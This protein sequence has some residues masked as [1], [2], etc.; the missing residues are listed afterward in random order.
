VLHRVEASWQF[1]WKWH[2]AT[3]NRPELSSNTCQWF[4]SCHPLHLQFARGLSPRSITSTT[5]SLMLMFHF[6]PMPTDFGNFP[7]VQ[8]G[9]WAHIVVGQ[10]NGHTT[11]R[12]HIYYYDDGP[13]FLFNTG[14]FF[15][16]IGSYKFRTVYTGILY[17]SSWRTSS[18]RFRGVGGGNLFLA[19]VSKNW[20]D[21][22]NEIQL[23]W[24]L[25]RVDTEA[26][27]HAL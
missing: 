10:N 6:W 16:G 12:V 21:R 26:H 3:T 20:P 7:D 1:P 8:S 5:H 4:C 15:L 18:K 9:V 19:Q 11:D 22:F 17:H 24:L 23:W 14:A 2:P 13:P 27:L 25:A